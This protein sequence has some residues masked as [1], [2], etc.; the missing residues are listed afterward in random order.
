LDVRQEEVGGLQGA[1]ARLLFG[2]KGLICGHDRP[3]T[4]QAAGACVP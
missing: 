4:G 3:K 2:R 1:Y